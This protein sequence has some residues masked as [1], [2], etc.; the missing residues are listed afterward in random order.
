MSVP[1]EGSLGRALADALGWDEST[2]RG[3]EE[4][5]G[6]LPDGARLAKL[7]AVLGKPPV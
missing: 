3:Y 6:R 1:E 2:I 5:G 4:D 7:R